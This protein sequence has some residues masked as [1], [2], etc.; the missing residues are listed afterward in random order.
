ME[1]DKGLVIS[2]EEIK[3]LIGQARSINEQHYA[4]G[5]LS[6]MRKE[7]L[8]LADVL[9]KALSQSGQEEHHGAMNAA[10]DLLLK[11]ADKLKIQIG[12]EK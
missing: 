9:K 1:R 12:E 8:S 11:N 7:G 5:F 4:L 6:V 10:H 2:H 3:F